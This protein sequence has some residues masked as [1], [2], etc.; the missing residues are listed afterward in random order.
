MILILKSYRLG[1]SL[2][3]Y[4]IEKK[5]KIVFLLFLDY[6][7]KLFSHRASLWRNSHPTPKHTPTLTDIRTYVLRQ[8]TRRRMYECIRR[9]YHTCHSFKRPAGLFKD[10]GPSQ[11]S[12][13]VSQGVCVEGEGIIFWG[14]VGSFSAYVICLAFAF[15]CMGTTRFSHFFNLNNIIELYKHFHVRLSN[16]LVSI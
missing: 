8:T 13:S 1:T 14:S 9:V 7:Y 5:M 16:I 12:R 4:L 10:S 15:F 2:L 3:L 11:G 6:F